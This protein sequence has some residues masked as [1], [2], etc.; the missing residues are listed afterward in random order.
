MKPR[1]SSIRWFERLAYLA[2]LLSTINSVMIMRKMYGA[3]IPGVP[4]GRRAVVPL[5]LLLTL[6]VYIPMILA[7]ARR[8]SN[9][10]RLILTALLGLHLVMLLNLPAILAQE[11]PARLLTVI[12]FPISAVL[13]WLLFREDSK[14]WFSRPPPVDPGVFR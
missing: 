6:A 11:D 9:N 8:A 5:M 3:A 7:A 14:E 4:D 12:Q 13:I 10:A 2:L 1:P